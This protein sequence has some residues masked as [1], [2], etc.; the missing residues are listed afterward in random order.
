[1]M[2]SFIYGLCALTAA[3]CAWLL[4]R[5]YKGSRYQLL[6]WSGLFFAVVTINNLLL[7]ADKLVFPMM[8]LSVLRYTV[9][10]AAHGLLLFGLISESK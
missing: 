5:A 6:F 10:L 1:M 3:L 4:L 2:A 9:A 7:V 8:D